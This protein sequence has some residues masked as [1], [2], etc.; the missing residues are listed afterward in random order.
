MSGINAKAVCVGDEVVV[1]FSSSSKS[2]EYKIFLYRE[3]KKLNW[4]RRQTV[5]CTFLYCVAQWLNC[6]SPISIIYTH[7]SEAVLKLLV[8]ETV[9]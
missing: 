4:T 7:S 3:D 2:E 9:L 6:A 1:T 8:T 5:C